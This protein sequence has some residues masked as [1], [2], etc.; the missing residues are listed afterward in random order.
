MKKKASIKI[1]VLGILVRLQL[2]LLM[3][4]VALPVVGPRV[5]TAA[6]FPLRP[7][8]SSSVSNQDQLD[9][10]ISKFNRERNPCFHLITLK[11]DIILTRSTKK[12]SNNV[13]ISGAYLVINGQGF[14][15][16]GAER[17]RPFT[18]AAKTVV[19]MVQITATG[20]QSSRNGG[21]IQNYGA[22]SLKGC[23]IT[24]NTAYFSGG[25]IYNTGTLIINDSTISDN[26]SGHSEDSYDIG[27]GGGICNQGG[28]VTISDSTVSDNGSW[29]SGAGIYSTGKLSVTRSTISNNGTGEWGEGAG[30]CNYEGEA[31]IDFSTIA[32]NGSEAVGGGIENS[33]G[34][35]MTITNSTI[36]GNYGYAGG[37]GIICYGSSTLA[38]INSTV[39]GNVDD[40]IA[41]GECT[42][43]LTNCSVADNAPGAG[44]SITGGTLTLHN[45]IIAN[46]DPDAVDCNNSGD[47]SVIARSNLIMDNGE[48]ACNLINGE[49]GNLVGVDPV[50]G[51]LK[52]NGGPTLTHALLGGSP[53]ID[54]GDNHLAVDAL[55]RRLK[56]DQRGKGYPRSN[57]GTRLPRV[58]M[59]A[60]ELNL[61]ISPP[62]HLRVR[63]VGDAPSLAK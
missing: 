23:T 53:A 32:D 47:A 24:D 54:A 15:V 26:Y 44:V 21:G 61:S 16:Q 25:G 41:C 57:R 38:L 29:D 56:T 3:T 33:M 36:S 1:T 5:S 11:T 60:F 51:E 31:T 45:T 9:D 14:K 55:G 37:G 46:S 17:I 35:T 22:L 12:I 8:L 40:G 63:P 34:G 18:I 27:P 19:A 2:M 6:P 52:D 48:D 20:G 49:N 7:C 13:L 42:L 50:L 10:A 58:D 59:G 28:R 43:T 30:I 62:G 4:A 39:S